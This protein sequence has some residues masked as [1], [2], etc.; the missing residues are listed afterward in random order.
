MRLMMWIASIQ[1]LRLPNR[2]RYKGMSEESL[3]TADIC[4]LLAPVVPQPHPVHPTFSVKHQFSLNKASLR[5]PVLRLN[6]IL[7]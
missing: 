1:V 3:Q 7:L 4:V 2:A 6:L 5:L